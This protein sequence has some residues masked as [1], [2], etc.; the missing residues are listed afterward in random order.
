MIYYYIGCIIA[1]ISLIIHWINDPDPET[2]EK[3]M[4]GKTYESVYVKDIV[5]VIIFTALS[6]LT[7]LTYLIEF[8]E[9][10]WNFVSE[11]CSKILNKRLFRI[12]RK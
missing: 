2:I 4:S 11:K 6:W 3:N 8:N 12:E 9:Q 10:I 1:F 5:Y 7:V